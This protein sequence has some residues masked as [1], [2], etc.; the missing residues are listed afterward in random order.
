MKF[1]IA[2]S[3]TCLLQANTNCYSQKKSLPTKTD[4]LYRVLQRIPGL[5]FSC[6]REWFSFCHPVTI[7]ADSRERKEV[8]DQCFKN[9][10]LTYTFDGS[11]LVIKPHDVTGRVTN[12]Q[13]EPIVG[14]TVAIKGTKR[15]TITDT[16]GMF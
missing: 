6:P 2:L 13:G 7:T 3:M 16:S 11:K 1:L 4:S 14:V 10:P 15:S 9:Q 5:E 8:L 12:E